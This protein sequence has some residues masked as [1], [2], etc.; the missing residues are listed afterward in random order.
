[1][2]AMILC[3]PEN[4]LLNSGESPPSQGSVGSPLRATRGKCTSCGLSRLPKVNLKFTYPLTFLI[5]IF[6]YIIRFCFRFVY[7]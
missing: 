1:M 5:L 7:S 4:R 2:R 6:L 3:P